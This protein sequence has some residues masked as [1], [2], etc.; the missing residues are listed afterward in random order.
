[1]YLLDSNILIYW[2]KDQGNVATNIQ[3]H[4]AHTI[5]IP[6]PALFELE[7]GTSKSNKPQQQRAQIDQVMRLF[8]VVS[9]DYTSARQAGLLRGA[10]ESQ[11]SI[12]GA[13]D[14]L[15]VGIALAN[16]FTVVT[17]NVREFSRV[18]GLTVENWYD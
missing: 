8:E 12:I 10:L 3:R 2:F 16:Q 13:Y 18:P 6:T 1:M 9:L 4:P 7:Y 17:R 5:K 11:G 14:L 15:I